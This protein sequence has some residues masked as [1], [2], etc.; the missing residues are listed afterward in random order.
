MVDEFLFFLAFKIFD[1]ERLE[2]TNLCMAD[3]LGQLVE[4]V[5]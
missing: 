1:R 2:R 3:R 4:D 5:K